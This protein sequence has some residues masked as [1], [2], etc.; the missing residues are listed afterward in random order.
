MPWECKTLEYTR[1]EFVAKAIAKNDSISAL[2]R[3]YGISRPTA[4]KWIERY[5]NGE[6]LS[7]KSHEP[8]FKPLKTSPHIE[9]LILNA[10]VQHPTWG[11]RK[12][13]QFLQNKGYESLPAISTISDILK[14]NG[15]ISKQD[16]EAHTPWKRFEKDLPNQLWQMDFKGHF[17]MLNNDRCHPLTILDDHSR[18]SLCIDAKNNEKWLNTKSSIEKVFCEYGLPSAIL[19]D[20]GNP[21]GDSQNGYSLFDLWMMQLNIL[22]IHGRPL[23][24]QT[25]GK[26]ERFHRTMKNDLLSRVPIHNIEHAQ[27]EFNSFRYCYNY[28]RPHGALNLDVPA[29]HY[30]P[31]KRVYDNA[32]YEPQYDDGD[33]LRK[34]N[35]KGYISI[36]RHRYYLGETF[37][38]KYLNVINQPDDIVILCYGNFQIAKIDLNEQLFISKKI[39]RLDNKNCK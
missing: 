25:Q 28:E 14:R 10:R 36:N 11:A 9:E 23:H 16:S 7:N 5:K 39:Y 38:D 17:A 1:Q 29:K 31:S 3:Q 34:V 22:P 27:K 32:L 35:C 21:W 20:N 15:C 33:C 12:L 24:P 4:Y 30:K 13:K 2:C 37:I 26:E 19:C 6:N 18:Y 8:L